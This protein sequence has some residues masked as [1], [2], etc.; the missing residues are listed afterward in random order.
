MCN[1]NNPKYEF[2]D[3]NNNNN[4]DDIKENKYDNSKYINI[5]SSLIVSICVSKYYGFDEINK[6][7]NNKSFKSYIYI[8]INHY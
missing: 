5:S 4:G 1:F 8:P 3:N 6:L 2:A 7:K